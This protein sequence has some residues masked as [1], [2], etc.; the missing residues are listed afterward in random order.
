MST[1]IDLLGR[2]PIMKPAISRDEN[3]DDLP[4]FAVLCA[5]LSA[6]VVSRRSY[7]RSDN[8]LVAMECGTPDARNLK[9]R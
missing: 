2:A 4:P 1:A 6:K 3:P 5:P 8:G 9:Q 7:A